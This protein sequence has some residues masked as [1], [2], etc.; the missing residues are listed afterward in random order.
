VNQ[1][2]RTSP[3]HKKSQRHNP[4]SMPSEWRRRNYRTIHQG[5]RDKLDPIVVSK[6]HILFTRGLE[7]HPNGLSGR[8][9]GLHLLRS[10]IAYLLADGPSNGHWEDSNGGPSQILPLP[11]LAEGS[12]LFLL[13]LFQGCAVLCLGRDGVFWT[14]STLTEFTSMPLSIW[15]LP[16]AIPIPR[17]SLK[18]QL[19]LVKECLP[20]DPASPGLSL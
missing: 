15:C 8:S 17:L 19:S 9:Q 3:D 4:C 12:Q 2:L 6:G 10:S 11:L 16:L 13:L 1:I 20:L 18:T 14:S 7:R 5:L